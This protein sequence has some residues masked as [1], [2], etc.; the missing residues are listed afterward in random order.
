MVAIL[1]AIT[2][3]QQKWSWVLFEFRVCK[4]YKVLCE[5]A[6]CTQTTHYTVSTRH[7]NLC[8]LRFA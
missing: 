8:M 7:I 2:P 6:L 5:L 1:L 3:K 4:C